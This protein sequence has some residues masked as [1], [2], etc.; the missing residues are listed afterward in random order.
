M[1]R[2]PE[3]DGLRVFAATVIVAYHLCGYALPWGWAAVDL[4]FVLSGYQITGN[5]LEGGGDPGFF[6]AFYARRA[7]RILPI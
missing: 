7:L 6:R 5:I 4:F 2:V 1:E 3:L